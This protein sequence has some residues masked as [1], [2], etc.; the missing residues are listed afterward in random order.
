[1]NRQDAK[2]AKL[3]NINTDRIEKIPIASKKYRSL[4]KNR[5]PDLTKNIIGLALLASWRLR[6]P[7][8]AVL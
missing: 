4:R 8:K 1:M 2:D 6:L 5:S 7:Q 3:Q